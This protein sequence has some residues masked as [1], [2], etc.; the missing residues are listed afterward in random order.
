MGHREIKILSMSEIDYSIHQFSVFFSFKM[1]EIF[2]KDNNA[3]QEQ[4]GP[5]E[6]VSFLSLVCHLFCSIEKLNW[7]IFLVSFLG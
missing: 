5:T 6:A 4:K 7:R 2:K 1:K 3:K